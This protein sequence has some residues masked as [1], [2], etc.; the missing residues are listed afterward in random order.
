MIHLH[1]ALPMFALAA[2]FTLPL[3]SCA[4]QSIARLDPP[5]SIAFV[6]INII[7]GTGGPA[8]PHQDVVVAGDRIV[9]I[10]PTGGQFNARPIDGRGKTLLPGY[11]DAHAHI[12]SRGVSGSSGSPGLS[13]TDN[14]ER[15]LL[16]GVTTVFDM[17]G[18]APQLGDL[19]A[20]IEKGAIAA[21]RLFH[22][23]LMITGKGSHP[24]PLITA[25]NPFGFL[26]Q[27]VL[28]QVEN[29]EDIGRV[30]DVD[31]EERVDFVKIAI[32]RMPRGTPL[33]DRSLMQ[34][35]VREARRRGHRV[36]VH[37]GDADD[38][39]AAARAG[40]TALAH[41]PW[42][43]EITPDKAAELKASGVVVTTTV[44]MWESVALAA[45]GR[46]VASDADR[47]LIPAAMIDS[48]EHPEHTDPAVADVGAELFE[49]KVKRKSSLA[50]L[51]KAGVPLMV[52]TDASV[53]S[54]WPGSSYQA[55]L[56]SLLNAGLPVT[57][58]IVAMTSRPAQ[59]MAGKHAD[60]GV[61]QTGKCADLVV[62][63][64]DPVL[65]PAALWNIDTVV[66]A[67][68]IVKAVVTP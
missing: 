49:N 27:F 3:L 57:E 61:V 25:L 50:A 7:D 16:S 37:A 67:G 9:S 34:R 66:R 46:F 65:D 51:L 47:K 13:T 44:A 22:T 18:P 59:L 33:L 42:R 64:G 60:F 20:R 28:P 8:R 21:P 41:L 35:L 1:R 36:F 56:R 63:N 24:I 39:L 53:P 40:A 62:V 32:D 5:E 30:L 26:L 4:T 38:A 31:D 17:S 2:S 12:G 58:L 29:D 15:W 45:V 11:V 68:R 43:G 52:G 19:A 54:V 55:E 10:G 23:H 48:A 6:D 14:L